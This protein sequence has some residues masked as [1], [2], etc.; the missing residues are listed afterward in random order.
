MFHRFLNCVCVKAAS[1]SPTTKPSDCWMLR[2][3]TAS[4]CGS[5]IARRAATDFKFSD[6]VG[7]LRSHLTT[8]RAVSYGITAASKISSM[9]T[10]TYAPVRLAWSTRKSST[11]CN[12]ACRNTSISAHTA[13]TSRWLLRPIRTAGYLK[14]KRRGTLWSYPMQKFV[15]STRRWPSREIHRRNS[16]NHHLFAPYSQHLSC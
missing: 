8:R 10:M 14:L 16:V 12:R 1:P 13:D 5:G 6:T 7:L 2:R 11:R 3:Y 15:L 4:L 9:N